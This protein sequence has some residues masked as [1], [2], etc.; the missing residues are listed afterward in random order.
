MRIYKPGDEEKLRLCGR[1]AAWRSTKLITETQ[2]LAIKAAAATDLKR[3]TVIMRILMFIFTA[4]LAA[5]TAAF[6]VW[7]LD[8]RGVRHAVWWAFAAGLSYTAAEL[9]AAR[10]R[11]YR[12]GA[13]EA[14]AA[15]AL[16]LALMTVGY[17]FDKGAGL[18][19]DALSAAMEVFAAAGAFALFIRFG[20]L[21]M[22]LAGLLALA[23][24]PFTFLDGAVAQRGFLAAI[25]ILGLVITRRGEEPVV[26]LF[27]R[28]ETSVLFASLFLGLCL[29]VNMRLVDFGP[30]N[31]RH[32][33][34][35]L[36]EVPRPVYWFTYLL[37][38]LLPLAGLAA[39]LKARRRALIIASAVG[40]IVALCTNKD[41]LGFQHYAWDPAV[42]GALL[43]V[44][45]AVLERRLRKE[46]GGY[47]AA[48]LV[49][50]ASDG[51]EAAAL[52][53]GAA[54]LAP[55][56]PEAGGVSFGGGESGGAGS[57]RSF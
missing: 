9:L 7:A 26:P 53:A 16:V 28:D 17:F 3:T 27:K 55:A 19:G 34:A 46:W 50:P 2:F 12:H 29:A 42:L 40:L 52:A 54:G 30:W 15:A 31:Y 44:I 1:A 32:A 56:K 45:S 22:A 8:L 6:V 43:I 33:L 38:F 13:E 25:L 4:L 35:P 48:E 47:T 36:A 49:V 18:H 57:S 10:W 24:I 5:A 51:L 37:T 23:A 14:F 41:Y 20:F 39:G 11:F 21:Y